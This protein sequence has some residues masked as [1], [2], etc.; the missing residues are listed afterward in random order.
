MSLS[1]F[2]LFELRTNSPTTIFHALL[3]E[4]S[5]PKWALLPQTDLNFLNW[6]RRFS[7][8]FFHKCVILFYETNINVYRLVNVDI[9]AT[10]ALINPDFDQVIIDDWNPP[11]TYFQGK[12]LTNFQNMKSEWWLTST[13]NSIFVNI[14]DFCLE[15]LEFFKTLFFT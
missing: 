10:E 11:K 14:F 15:N 4:S 2:V 1:V 6:C 5:T 3:L 8:P 7:G 12:F 13:R 9:L